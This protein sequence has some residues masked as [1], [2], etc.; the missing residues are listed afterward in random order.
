MLANQAK[1][2]LDLTYVVGVEGERIG[3]TLR[4]TPKRLPGAGNMILWQAVEELANCIIVLLLELETSPDNALLEGERL[5]RDEVR[6][7]L[8]DLLLLLPRVLEVVLEEVR[9]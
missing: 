9:L 5:V 7:D 4:T 2:D 3:R 1:L 8:L 6:D